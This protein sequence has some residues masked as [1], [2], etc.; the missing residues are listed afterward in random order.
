MSSLHKHVP[1]RITYRQYEVRCGVQCGCHH[2]RARLLQAL[3][4]QAGHETVAE[5]HG[6]ERQCTEPA[7]DLQQNGGERD[8]SE[9]TRKVVRG[10]E[11]RTQVHSGVFITS[12]HKASTLRGPMDEASSPV[13]PSSDARAPSAPAVRLQ[14]HPWSGGG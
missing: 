11:S 14:E 6:A 1:R 3:D 10:I 5:Y 13:L 8:A 4:V 12:R 9:V 2:G 7:Y